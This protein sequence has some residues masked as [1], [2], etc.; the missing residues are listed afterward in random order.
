MYVRFIMNIHIKNKIFIGTLSKTNEDQVN[1]KRTLY[2]FLLSG[3][4]I[5][6]RFIVDM[7]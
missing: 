7:L 3:N 2:T 5:P 6:K 4:A 1:K